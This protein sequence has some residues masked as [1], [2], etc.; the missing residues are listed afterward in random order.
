MDIYKSKF[1]LDLLAVNNYKYLIIICLIFFVF[2]ETTK[3][4]QQIT[5]SDSIVSLWLNEMDS[6]CISQYIDYF[7]IKEK[8]I[9]MFKIDK[10][11]ISYLKDKIIDTVQIERIENYFDK[12]GYITK[13]MDT[14]FEIRITVFSNDY[15]TLQRIIKRKCAGDY[16][17]IVKFEII[18]E[19]DKVDKIM[20][21]RDDKTNFYY[22]DFDDLLL[23]RRRDNHDNIFR[24][25][26]IEKMRVINKYLTYYYFF[27]LFES[28]KIITDELE[29]DTIGRLEKYIHIG[30][31]IP[32]HIDPPKYLEY[33]YLADT[34]IIKRY[35]S[36]FKSHVS[37]NAEEPSTIEKVIC[38]NGLP[39]RIEKRFRNEPVYEL[40]KFEYEFYE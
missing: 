28:S 24:Y 1:D 40:L 20:R 9:K 16:C 26:E 7:K 29:Y 15:D 32:D 3:S 30:N 5:K 25:N 11:Q 14:S 31:N 37:I 38:K 22:N 10:Y 36:T 19:N 8:K 12:N 13:S 27:S 17:L 34:I 23:I 33:S 2:T 18:Y 4:N 6:Y 35:N 39:I 21:G